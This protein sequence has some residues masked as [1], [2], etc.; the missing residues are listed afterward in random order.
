MNDSHL[1]K[2]RNTEFVE[3]MRLDND[4][5]EATQKWFF[6]GYKYEYSYHFTWLG[7]PIIQYPQD[8][9]AMQEIIWQVKPDLIIETGIARG[10]SL[11]FYASMLELLGENGQVLGLDI[12]IREHNRIAIEK[13][14]MFKR[15]TMIQGS[16]IAPE[17]AQKVYDFAEVKQRILVVLDSN[18][19]HDHVLKEL[20]LYSHLVTKGSYLVVF[21]TVVEDLPEDLFPDRPWGKGNNPKT[22]VWEF[23]KT[24]DRFEI[25]KDMEA[26][27]LITVAPDGY[28]KCVK[29]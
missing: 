14:P 16:S 2:T 26:K 4:L 18:H 1:F 15:I 12:D 23:L 7:L 29:D 13:H 22:A 17:I 25:D 11:I 5:K 3:Q 9:M 19:T 10:G 8:M 6:C 24:S 28:L 27:L 21:D 20:Q